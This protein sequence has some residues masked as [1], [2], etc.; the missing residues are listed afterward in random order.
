MFNIDRL[1]CQK[2]KYIYRLRNNENKFDGEKERNY[3]KISKT[4][5]TQ[6][7]LKLKLD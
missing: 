4:F 6:I 3:N 7:I 1:N 5:F 2:K